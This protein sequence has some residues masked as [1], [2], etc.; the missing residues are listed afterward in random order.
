MPIRR[1]LDS[2]FH[3]F[4]EFEVPATGIMAAPVLR[5]DFSWA[6][7]EAAWG[8]LPVDRAIMVQVRVEAE[9][10]AESEDI[11]RVAAS[12]PR[13]AG[14]VAGNLLEEPPRRPEL[15]GLAANPMVRGVRRVTQ[16]HPDPTYL[17]RPEMVSGFRELAR[18]GLAGEVCVKHFQLDGV[19][20][21]AAALPELSLVLDHLGKPDMITADQPDWRRRMARLAEFPNVVVKVSPVVQQP[22]DPRLPAAAVG[23]IVRHVVQEFGW[24]RVLFASNWPVATVITGFGEWVDLVVGALPGASDDELDRL[25]YR[26][27]ARVWRLAD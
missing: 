1:I 16:F 20:E 6:D 14:M 2:H 15:A 22:D 18:L 26:N 11:A 5:R 21:L 10:L 3:L 25:F 13:L 8:G 19:I 12:E 4:R 24:D 23:P 17:A 27:A 7:Y 9:G